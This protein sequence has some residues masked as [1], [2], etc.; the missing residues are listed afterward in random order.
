MNNSSVQ[1]TPTTEK[2]V[3]LIVHIIRKNELKCKRRKHLQTTKILTRK[4]NT[5]RIV[6]KN[7][8]IS[9]KIRIDLLQKLYLTTTILLIIIDN[10]G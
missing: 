5:E 4:V 9:H 2:S 6:E 1:T 8:T 10:G 7:T 3:V